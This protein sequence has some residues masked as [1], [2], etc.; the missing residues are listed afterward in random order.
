MHIAK[1]KK[2]LGSKNVPK[3]FDLWQEIKSN[4][5]KAEYNSSKKIFSTATGHINGGLNS[6]TGKPYQIITVKRTEL[7]GIPN[8]ITQIEGKKG[9]IDRNYYGSDGWQEKQISNNGHGH[10]KEEAMGKHGEH[11][12]DYSYGANRK[13]TRTLRDLIDREKKEN[14]D[15]FMIA[16]RLKDRINE[17]CAHVLFVYNGKNCGVDPF[18]END[19][20]MWYGD[21]DYKATSIDEVMSY[22]LFDGKSLSDIAE[23]IEDVEGL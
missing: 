2:V 20:D 10:A 16:K 14:G 22:P 5:D 21:E 12:H 9:G 18:S 23:H 11:A 4:G 6:D 3:T 15:I 17:I 13:L 19:F 8:T 1:Y 7:R